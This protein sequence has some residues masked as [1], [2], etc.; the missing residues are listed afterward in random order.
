MPARNSR[1]G[2]S[3]VALDQHVLA[4]A[5]EAVAAKPRGGAAAAA[6]SARGA[7]LRTTSRGTC[8][9]RAAG[10]P[11]RGEKGKMW[12]NT[13]SQSS[14]SASVLAAIASVSVGKPA[15]RSAPIAISGRFAFSRST[16]ATA[17]GAAVAALHPLEDHVVARL[18]REVEVRHHAR[19]P[20]TSANSRSSISTESS[21]DRRSRGSAGHVPQD[22]L[23][24]P[25]EARRA[26]QIG[27][28]AGQIDAGQ[29]DLAMAGVDQRGDA[30][31]HRAGGHRAAVAAAEGITQKVQR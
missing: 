20:V 4:R 22:A 6:R 2:R 5:D 17:C 13:M 21:D 18:Q 9:I 8:G 19:L 23:D 3:P 28:V 16:I 7:G 26:G 15:I 14:I 25:A 31:D 12:P 24:Q 29:H 30:I 27:A 1:H 10:V 11:G